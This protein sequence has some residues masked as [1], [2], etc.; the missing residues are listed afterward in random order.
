MAADLPGKALRLC[1]VSSVGGHLDEVMALFPV[2]R[3][4]DWFFVVNAEGALPEEIRGRTVRIVHSERDWKLLVNLW[5]AFR[6]LRERRPHAI[7]SCGAGPAVPF[8]LVGKLLGAKV[9]FVES[10]AAV[11]RPTLTGRILYRIA[12]RFLY[13]WETLRPFFPKGEFVGTLF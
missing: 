11:E 4:T 12:D 5:E 1:V 13:Q 2:F 7:L 3:E 8:A 10:F 9:I 6:I